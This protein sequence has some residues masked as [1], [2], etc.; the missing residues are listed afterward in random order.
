MMFYKGQSHAFICYS[1]M[2]ISRVHNREVMNSWLYALTK[3]VSSTVCQTH[4]QHYGKFC[5][6]YYRIPCTNNVMEN[7]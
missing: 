6:L 3:L 5:I 4:T 2:A 7:L 1:Y